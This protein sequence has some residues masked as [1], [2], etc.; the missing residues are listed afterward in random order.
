MDA[1]LK[2]CSTCGH[3]VSNNTGACAYCGAIYSGGGAKAQSDEKITAEEIRST[4]SEPPVQAAAMPSAAGMSEDTANAG[5]AAGKPSES[6]LSQQVAAEPIAA[7]SAEPEPPPEASAAEAEIE[8]ED[9]SAEK[10]QA[11]AIDPEAVR[12]SPESKSDP[13]IDLK[14]EWDREPVSPVEPMS[15]GDLMPAGETPA[16]AES[17]SDDSTHRTPEN[18]AEDIP[19]PEQ[20]VFSQAP[21]LL[22]ATAEDPDELETLGA[23]IIEMIEPQ[24]SEDE[25]QVSKASDEG[26]FPDITPG[27]TQERPADNRRPNAVQET[28]AEKQAGLISEA[29]GDTI[30]LEPADEVQI[31]TM[32]AADK[33]EEK[34]K[35]EIQK[36]ADAAKAGSGAAAAEPTMRPDV[37]KIEKAARDMKSAIEKQ[38][39]KHIDVGNSTDK[40]ANTDKAVALKKQKAALAKAQAQKKQKLLLAKAAALKRKKAVEAK[41]QAL[42]KQ[43]EASAGSET[44]K[45]ENP[46]A[47]S[48]QLGTKTAAV[49][50]LK[51]D[52]KMQD[53]IKKY[54]GQAIGINY[55]NSAEIREALLEKVNHEYFSVFV[56]DK[57]L[58]YSYPL[59]TILT[60]IEGKDGV[61]TGSSKQPHKFNAVI[62]VY[63]LVLF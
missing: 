26:S 42:K 21:E 8:L 32:T 4:V 12:Y 3:V 31:P 43:R 18:Q 1:N 20:T 54:E 40:K 28:A 45:N 60:V 41:A 9:A 2:R 49:G 13:Q 30:L 14:E 36:S 6:I 46:A 51:A 17:H 33:S 57:Q 27:A 35:V 37:L 5:S 48:R 50:E 55:D 62:K 44:A 53:L 19:E 38:K 22:E 7:D 39:E 59:K 24:A 25:T 34:M 10:E 61:E 52:S 58:H 23:E 29:L 16:E 11:A 63:P 47:A 56:K 15:A